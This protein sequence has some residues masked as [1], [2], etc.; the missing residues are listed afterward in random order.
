VPRW[1]RERSNIGLY[2]SHHDPS[3]ICSF[4]RIGHF[5]SA[6]TA[7][8]VYKND[9]EF[10]PSKAIDD[11]SGTRWATN[12]N[13]RKCW[14]EIDLGTS[15]AFDGAYLSEGWDRVLE[16]TLEIQDARGT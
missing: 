2:F 9:K 11:D 15:R 8:N 14:M 13:V 7:S 16:F 6:A 5:G 3:W 12:D 1:I 4:L 10:E